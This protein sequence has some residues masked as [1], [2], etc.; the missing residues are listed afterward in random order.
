M[1]LVSALV[2]LLGAC[3]G[4]VESGV[5]AGSNDASPNDA[6]S[7]D[8]GRASLDA[9]RDAATDAGLGDAGSVCDPPCFEGVECVEAGDGQRCG[10]CPAGLEGDG[11]S[12]EDIDGCAGNPC[13]TGVTCTDVPA[14]DT[15]FTCG[16]CPV[17]TQGDGASCE[18]IDGCAGNPCFTGVT[19][20]D[21][22]APDTGF[23]CGPCPVGTQGDGVSCVDID[24]C[25]GNPCFAGVTCTDV[26]APDTGFTCGAC[27]VGT[28]GD[29]VSCL[30]IDGCA[31]NPCFAGVT[32]TDVPAPDIGF[33]CG[34]CP[35]GTEGDGVSCMDIDGCAGD[36]CFAGVTCT[37][38][39]APD[40]G[41]TCGAC[42]SGLQGDGRD[43]TEIDGCAGDPCL[44]AVCM[45]VPAPGTGHTCGTCAPGTS[46][47]DCA[48]PDCTG[49]RYCAGPVS[50]AASTFSRE[51]T[52]GSSYNVGLS[53]AVDTPNGAAVGFTAALCCIDGTG[54][55]G[56]LFADATHRVVSVFSGASR[57][58]IPPE[59]ALSFDGSVLHLFDPF[60]AYATRRTVN[61]TSLAL[62]LPA[63]VALSGRDW[64]PAVV[65]RPGGHMALVGEP[66]T[67]PRFRRFNAAFGAPVSTTLVGSPLAMPALSTTCGG[68]ALGVWLGST[69]T[70][71]LLTRAFN[72]E[73]TPLNPAGSVPDAEPAYG[74]FLS[75]AYRVS[76][77]GR[78]VVVAVHDAV[79]EL[80]ADGSLVRRTPS[81]ASSRRRARAMG[82]SWCDAT[83]RR[84]TAR[85]S[86]SSRGRPAR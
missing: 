45:D 21:V 6:G 83:R 77:D 25:A 10:E 24:G 5:D 39:P 55:A 75:R 63:S 43:C 30:D 50:G 20:T 17:G 86:S 3:S 13:F 65:P 1:S 72:R 29:E 74:Y 59:P 41:F 61:P 15:G 11:V 37:D 47:P 34:A 36:P 68:N 8:A 44:N 35:V 58:G 42:P 79:L 2:L 71:T 27:P 67:G 31:G 40:T 82:C 51:V 7:N 60:A 19:C 57:A 54:S 23:T 84:A 78:L 69:T 28:E 49:P 38:V 48:V 62:G 53:N 70:G 9:G 85:R 22:P 76:F 12:C 46:G 32:C 73:A 52:S 80:R 4:T 14:P 33:T 56:V 66:G 18:D 16:P 81:R 64:P 26:P